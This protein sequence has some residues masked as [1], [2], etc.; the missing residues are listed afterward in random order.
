MVRSLPCPTWDMDL[1]DHFLNFLG[2]IPSKWANKEGDGE[3]DQHA[4]KADSL[5]GDPEEHLLLRSILPQHRV[6]LLP[7]NI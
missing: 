2:G 4:N 7:E 5:G 3:V 6:L 1:L